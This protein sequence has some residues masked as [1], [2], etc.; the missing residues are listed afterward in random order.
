MLIVYDTKTGNVRRFIEKLDN[1]SVVQ[2]NSDL[3]VN[4]PYV[5]VTYTTGFG[6]VPDSTSLFL[7]NNNL[8]LKGVSS[9]G[10]KVWGSNFARAAYLISDLYKVPILSTFELSGTPSDVLRFKTSLDKL[11]QGGVSSCQA[12]Q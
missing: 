8:Y 9:S 1:A 7:G 4:E 2:I 5:L 11:Q 10:N 12:Q 3:V 6:Q